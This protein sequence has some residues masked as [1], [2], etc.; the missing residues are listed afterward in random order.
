MPVLLESSRDAMSRKSISSNGTYDPGF[1]S[2]V[3]LAGLVT[4]PSETRMP[5]E[6][7]SGK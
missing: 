7:T 5:L 1:E 4:P 2:V 3:S 6:P